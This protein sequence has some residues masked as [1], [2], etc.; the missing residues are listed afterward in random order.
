MKDLFFPEEP[1]ESDYDGDHSSLAAVGLTDGSPH[2]GGI[3]VQLDWVED[4]RIPPH[5][6]LA[7]EE[8]AVLS[9]TCEPPD[10]A[11]SGADAKRQRLSETH[12]AEQ[13]QEQ[14][15]EQQQEQPELQ[16]TGQDELV[17]D[18]A[19][20]VIAGLRGAR[21]AALRLR[22]SRAPLGSTVARASR[23]SSLLWML[24]TRP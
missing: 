5:A 14:T 24:P 11:S 20:K 16:G 8:V 17:A 12:S 2:A 23:T 6:S 22:T 21:V 9:T 4:A 15:H 3:D 7:G 18:L 19:F 10:G 1:R 13:K